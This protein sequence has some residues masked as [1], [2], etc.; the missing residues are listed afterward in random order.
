M[1]RRTGCSSWRCN[2]AGVVW[3]WRDADLVDDDVGLAKAK[4]ST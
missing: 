3:P 2:H 1:S 4:L